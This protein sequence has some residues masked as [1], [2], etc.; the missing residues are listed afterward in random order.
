MKN[1]S[2]KG[3]K[4]KILDCPTGFGF[5]VEFEFYYEPY[6][7]HCSPY[8]ESGETTEY[9]TSAETNIEEAICDIENKVEKQA[10]DFNLKRGWD[11]Q[12]TIYFDR[13]E[14]T[15]CQPEL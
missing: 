14:G 3:D 1:I 13:Y 12:A 9:L 7:P 4:A 6:A 11:W 8:D 15:P 10:E 5:R 2:F